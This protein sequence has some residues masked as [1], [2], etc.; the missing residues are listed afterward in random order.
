MRKLFAILLFTILLSRCEAYRNDYKFTI[1]IIDGIRRNIKM[2]LS[3]IAEDI[4]FISL[5]TK[6]ECTVGQI[7]LLSVFGDYIVVI[8]DLPQILLFD[9]AGKFV[10]KIGDE[11]EFFSIHGL[12]VVNSELFIWDIH[13]NNTLCYDL[14]TGKCIRTKRHD[15]YPSSMKLFNDSILVYY[16][17]TSMHDREI[18]FYNIHILSLDFNKTDSLWIDREYRLIKS[19]YIDEGRVNTYMKNGNMYIWDSNIDTVFYLNKHFEKKFGYKFFLGKHALS[20]DNKYNIHYVDYM[21]DDEFMIT[22]VIETD[23][24]FFIEGLLGRRYAKNIL[25]D[26]TTKKSRDIIF[27][28]DLHDAGFHNDIDGSIPFWP[29]GQVSQNVLYDYI[30]PFE[31]K[32]LMND[33]YYKTI[34]FRDKAKNEAIRNCVDFAKITDNPIIFL[35]TI[36]NE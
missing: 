27:N 7:Q 28:L 36:K 5:E 14:N 30:S 11:K 12:V 1:N 20:E 34:E 21:K 17:S 4:A 6:E 8:D 3:S 2:P 15:F 13:L 18:P 19:T 25:Y 9:K 35:A 29:K 26:K 33:P 24:F 23:K 32:R 22:K 31:L 16:A 10:R